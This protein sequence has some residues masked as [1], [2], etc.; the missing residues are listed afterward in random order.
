MCWLAVHPIDQS[1]ICTCVCV[2]VWVWKVNVC[3]QEEWGSEKSW[4]CL[5]QIAWDNLHLLSIKMCTRPRECLFWWGPGRSCPEHVG[6]EVWTQYMIQVRPDL[7]KAR[8][9][10]F[11]STPATHLHDINGNSRGI[12]AHVCWCI[13]YH[14]GGREGGKEGARGR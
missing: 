3:V 1:T 13:V 14:M 11:G 12:Y 6:G 8:A 5:F 7:T 4:S 9:I 2:H 10:Q